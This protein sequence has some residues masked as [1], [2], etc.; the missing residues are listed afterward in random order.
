MDQFSQHPQQSVP[1]QQDLTSKFNNIKSMA[2]GD[3][4][5]FVMYMAQT[6]PQFASFAHNLVGK[7]PEQAFAEYGL[8]YSQFKGFL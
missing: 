2:G 4:S 3:A 6:N 1:R 5:G 7:T 8:D